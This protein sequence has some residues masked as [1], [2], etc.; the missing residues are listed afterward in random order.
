MCR[1]HH[2]GFSLIELMI[3]IAVLAVLLA[4]GFPSYQGSLRSNRLATSTNE[5]VATMSLARSEAIR[6]VRGAA[7]CPSADGEACSAAPDWND[8]W[9]VWRDLD[10]NN[11]ATADEVL[12]YVQPK[13]QMRIEGP[14]LI[15]FDSRGRVPA[16]LA[17]ITLEPE[18]CGGRPMRRIVQIRVTGQVA[19]SQELEECE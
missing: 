6:N 14:A 16:G 12:R 7:V 3:T 17:T 15:D 18:E 2:K 19:R 11:I 1:K 4:I 13:A 10:G 9:I 5:L 8:G